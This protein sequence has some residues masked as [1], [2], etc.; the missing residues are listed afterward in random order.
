MAAAG[1]A[2]ANRELV[3]DEFA[4]TAGEDRRT[5]GETCPL[6]LAFAGGEPSDE[7]ALWEYGAADRGAVAF[8]GIAEA[9]AGKS[10]Q[11]Q[12]GTE[13]CLT[14]PVRKAVVNSCGDRVGAHGTL[15]RTLGPAK[16]N[17]DALE[18]PKGYTVLGCWGLKRKFRLT[19]LH[20]V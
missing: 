6:L 15:R 18:P 8:G 2:Q 9:V 12:E 7:A 13:R 1:V 4:A 19:E 5:A 11:S 3:A 17:N 20:H 14:K 16:E 10:I